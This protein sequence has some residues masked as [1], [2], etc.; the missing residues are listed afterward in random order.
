LHHDA[1]VVTVTVNLGQSGDMAEI[2]EQ[3][4]SAGAIRAHVVDN[5]DAFARENVL[6]S[7][8]AGALSDGR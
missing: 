4:L 3:A 6:P 8:K 7:L 2:R 1:D 5:R